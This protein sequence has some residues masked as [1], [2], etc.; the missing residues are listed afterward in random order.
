M[1]SLSTH[2]IAFSTPEASDYSL[3]LGLVGARCF[4]R[5]AL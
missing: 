2:T 5:A 3:V 1:E 4:F